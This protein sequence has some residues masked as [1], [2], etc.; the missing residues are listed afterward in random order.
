MY[1]SMLTQVAGHIRRGEHPSLLDLER[2]VVADGIQVL[3]D[4]GHV[5]LFLGLHDFPQ[6]MDESK[7]SPCGLTCLVLVFI[8]LVA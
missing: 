1:S 7:G 2:K 8:F 4:G 6:D 5:F 3:S